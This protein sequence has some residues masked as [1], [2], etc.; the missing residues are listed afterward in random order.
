MSGWDNE[1]PEAPYSESVAGADADQEHQREHDRQGLRDGALRLLARREHS[2]LELS[3]KLLAKGWPQSRVDEVLDEL[4]AAGLQSDQRFAESFVR[5]RAGRYYGPRRIRAEL[6]QRGVD[7][8]QAVAA[9]ENPEIDFFEIAA[10]Y[11]QRKYRNADS[12]L[13]YAERAR[14]SQA[15]YR[16][17]FESDHLRDLF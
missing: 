16:R 4:A 14:R 17:G 2:C 8:W 13:S 3:R 11:Y 9:I 7:S 1:W 12:A 15:L 6:E 10:K 5:Q